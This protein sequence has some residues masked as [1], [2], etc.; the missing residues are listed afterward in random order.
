MKMVRGYGEKQE[1]QRLKAKT[2]ILEALADGKW[3]RFGEIVNCTKMSPA[4]VSKYLKQFET[5]EIIQKKVDIESGEYPYPAYYKLTRKG[6]EEASKMKI[7]KEVETY[8]S[9]QSDV[10]LELIRLLQGRLR[11]IFLKLETYDHPFPQPVVDAIIF[12]N[13]THETKMDE[14]VGKLKKKRPLEYKEDAML[15]DLATRFV[16]YFRHVIIEAYK[17]TIRKQKISKHKELLMMNKVGLDFDAILVLH[18]DGREILK[19]IDW[20]KEMKKAEY[21]DRLLE[22]GWDEFK[23]SISKPGNERKNWMID[24]IIEKTRNIEKAKARGIPDIRKLIAEVFPQ[25]MKEAAINPWNILDT[26]EKLKEAFIDEL[27]TRFYTHIKRLNGEK[28][29]YEEM[30]KQV[31]RLVEELQKEGIIEI[32]PIYLFK[33]NKEKAN[34]KQ[35]EAKEGYPDPMQFITKKIFNLH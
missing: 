26:P 23:K 33:L 17:D 2:A 25:K 34:K 10:R 4:T 3:H 31:R 35:W 9:R 1:K 29:T 28:E 30:E 20:E 16:D 14:I 12:L 22:K 11:E 32:T 6:F 27:T 8:P 18:F 13:K 5:S 21:I 24:E 15:R 19:Q 7:L